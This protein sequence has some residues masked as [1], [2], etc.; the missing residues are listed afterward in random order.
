VLAQRA[1]SEGPRWTRAVEDQSAPIP[2]EKTSELGREVARQLAWSLCSQNAHIQKV[3]AWDKSAS[4]RAR[5]WA[6]ENVARSKGQPRPLRKEGNRELETPRWTRAV[7]SQPVAL[8]FREYG[9]GQT[10]LCS[11]AGYAAG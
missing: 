7:A 10:A 11:L 9:R 4:R 3:L 8:K 2:E 1:A 5:G 6:G